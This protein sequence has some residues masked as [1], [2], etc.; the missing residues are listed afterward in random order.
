MGKLCAPYSGSPEARE[1][2]A[3]LGEVGAGRPLAAP[4]HFSHW[5][6]GPCQG[7]R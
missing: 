2:A 7:N 5:G 1:L 4:S 6:L 3:E